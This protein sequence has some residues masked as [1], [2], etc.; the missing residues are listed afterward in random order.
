M[1]SSEKNTQFKKKNRLKRS[2]ESQYIEVFKSAIFQGFFHRR[3][4]DF[5][6]YFCRNWR[7]NLSKQ[8]IDLSSSHN[9]TQFQKTN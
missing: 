7:P 9:F 5:F 2:L 6:I 1:S 3:R 4:R 8:I